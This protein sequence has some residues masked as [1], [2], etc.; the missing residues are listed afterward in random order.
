[1]RIT[2]VRRS[3]V[4]GSFVTLT[5]LFFA[6]PSLYTLISLWFENW[7]TDAIQPWELNSTAPRPPTTP[8]PTRPPPS[9]Y[10]YY[11]DDEDDENGY[12]DFPHAHPRKPLIPKIIHQTWT[13]TT[14]PPLW[15][16]AQQSCLSKHEDW[17]YMLW[18]D[19]KATHFIATEY[20]WF[21]E[22]WQSYEFNIQRADVIRYFVLAHYGGI[23]L[24]FDKVS[25][26]I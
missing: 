26:Q 3:V 11:D 25:C 18:T 2:T 6:G 10:P 14:I 23:Y 22:T 12:L 20:P 4:L 1:M 9:N 8:I 16:Q 19:A 5:F 21:L 17:Q 7:Q 24:D 13:N 15:K